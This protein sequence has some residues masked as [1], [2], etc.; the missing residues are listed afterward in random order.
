MLVQVALAGAVT[1]GQ[2]LVQTQRQERQ[3][4][5]AVAVAQTFLPH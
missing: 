5:A 3:T 1:A 4:Q 2:M